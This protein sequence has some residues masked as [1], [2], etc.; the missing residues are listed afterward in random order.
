MAEITDDF[1]DERPLTTEEARD[2]LKLEF[3]AFERLT[4]SGEIPHVRI[5]RRNYFKRAD[6]VEWF[7]SQPLRQQRVG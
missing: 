5:G 6:L 4:R 1:E 7:N 3:H 2:F